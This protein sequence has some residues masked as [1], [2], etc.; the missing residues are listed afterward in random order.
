MTK[1]PSSKKDFRMSLIS[2]T[3]VSNTDNCK[4]LLTTRIN[5]Q[6]SVKL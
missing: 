6:E 1:K 2:K 3:A 5:N 4:W